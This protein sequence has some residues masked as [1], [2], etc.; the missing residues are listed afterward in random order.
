MKTL[1]ISILITIGAGVM[2]SGWNGKNLAVLNEFIKK[3]RTEIG[4]SKRSVAVLDWDNTVVFN[5]IG[6][7]FFKWMME[8]NLFKYP[9]WKKISPFLTDKAAVILSNNCVNNNGFIDGSVKRCNEILTGI[10]AEGTLPD[11]TPAFS[12]YNSNLFQPSYAF[13]AELM[14][15]YTIINIRLLC[16]QAVKEAVREKAVFIYPQMK[17]LIEILQENG[18]DVWIISASPQIL[19]EPFAKLAGI[20][21]KN[22]IGI[23]NIV[24]NGILKPDFKGCGPHKDG[25]NALIT[26]K[27]GKR[28]WMNEVIFGITGEKALF[29]AEDISKRPLFGAGDSDTDLEFLQDVT[30][31]RLLIDRGKPEV[32]KEAR[33]NSDGKWIINEP[34]I[35]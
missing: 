5:D 13:L 34:F 27:A 31:L 21:E 2:M 29:P 16:E 9:D 12:G 19:V 10:Y 28:C 20:S 22:V 4:V 8:D 30:G 18:F 14:S 25:E 33:K 17:W 23:R 15:G 32:T 24:E 35:H 26:Y 7:Y 1:I 6:D 11:K 3:N